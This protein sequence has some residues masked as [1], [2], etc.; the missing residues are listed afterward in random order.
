MMFNSGKHGLM[1]LYQ[2]L[3]ILGSMMMF[4]GMLVSSSFICSQSISL[5]VMLRFFAEL[6]Q[7]LIHLG[8]LFRTQIQVGGFASNAHERKENFEVYNFSG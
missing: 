4:L 7:F 8:K 6:M 5:S 3:N 1:F 2:I